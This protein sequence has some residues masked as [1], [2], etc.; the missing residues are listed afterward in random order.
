MGRFHGQL[1]R[2]DIVREVGAVGC[3]DLSA[4]EEHQN[5]RQNGKAGQGTQQHT[6]AGD[7]PQLCHGA[8]VGQHGGKERQGQGRGSGQV[9]D[10]HVD[11]RMD[12]G[13]FHGHA[14]LSCLLVAHHP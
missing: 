14:A 5:G 1:E 13:G 12:Q 9:A 3:L 11:G 8:E 10:G 2:K 7:P 4:I 6:A